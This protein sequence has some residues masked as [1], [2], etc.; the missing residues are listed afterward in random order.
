M[1]AGKAVKDLGIPD[2]IRFT[3]IKRGTQLLLPR[4]DTVLVVKDRIW[5]A[6]LPAQQHVFRQWLKS[7]GERA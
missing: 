7:G 3:F 4:G 1:I 2:G 5:A 6:F